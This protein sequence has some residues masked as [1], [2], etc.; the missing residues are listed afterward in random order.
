MSELTETRAEL[1]RLEKQEQ[2]LV[3]ERLHVR[4]TIRTQRTKL[5]ELVRQLPTP[6]N[7]L[8]NE[9]LTYQTSRCITSLERYDT[10]LPQFLDNHQGHSKATHVALEGTS[11]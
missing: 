11:D 2:Q 1:A 8:P 6:I 5:E 4:A 7:R 3:K 10:A 9:T